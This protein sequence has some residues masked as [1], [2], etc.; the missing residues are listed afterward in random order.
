[1][2]QNCTKIYSH[3]VPN[4]FYMEKNFEKNPICTAMAGIQSVYYADVENIASCFQKSGGMEVNFVTNHGW[5]L[6][7]ADGVKAEAKH[8]SPWAWRHS[9][10]LTY[11]GNQQGVESD[12]MEMTQLRF[13]VKMIDNNGTEWLYGHICSPL[14]F[15]FDSD[16]DGEYD[17]E[18]AYQMTFESL[19]P[20]PERK[21]LS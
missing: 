7:E 15:R 16:N 11:H 21:I 13:L 6:I 8:E 19:C 9:V 5:S 12:L 4:T 18:T 10:K 17:G 2:T 1:M 14:R 3:F 20:G